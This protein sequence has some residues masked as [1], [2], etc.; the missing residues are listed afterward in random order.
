MAE[1]AIFCS[2][3]RKKYGR[4]AVLEGVDLKIPPGTIYALL[5]TNGAG[6]TTLIRSILGLI[7]RT[8]GFVDILGS[9]PWQAGP[10]LRQRIG[11]VSEEQGLYGWMK[12]AQIIDFCRDL[13]PQWN[14][15]FVADALKRFGLT[16]ETRIRTLSKGQKVR[17][18][19][20]LALAPEPDLLI[21]DEPMSGLDPLAQRDFLKILQQDAGQSG[22]TIFFSTHDLHDVETIATH[23]AILFDGRIQIAGPLDEIR[24]SIRRVRVNGRLGHLPPG[25]RELDSDGKETVYLIP[26]NTEGWRETATAGEGIT[27]TE[28]SPAL[29]EEVFLYYCSG[30]DDA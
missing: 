25:T 27:V 2:N 23:V 9:D 24:A 26:A 6:K 15:E 20:I 21:L 18:A 4:K 16:P 8:D 29:L 5:G 14:K 1:N 10:S 7:P 12:I 3:L 30:R 13:Y 19:L 17:L 22:R 11:Y 28:D